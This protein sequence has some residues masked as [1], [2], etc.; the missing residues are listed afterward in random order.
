MSEQQDGVVVLMM[1][2]NSIDGDG[3]VQKAAR[4]MADAGHRVTL[5]GQ[6]VGPGDERPLGAATVRRVPV[7]FAREQAQRRALDR[8]RRIARKLSRA[9]GALRGRA[10]DGG[11]AGAGAR[12]PRALDD[13]VLD[14]ARARFWRALRGDRCW[15]RLEPR[16]L[17]YERAYWPVVDQIRPQ[18]LHAH[19]YRMLGVAVRSARRLRAKGVDVRVVF[20]SHEFLPGV[21][22]PT[23]RWR[24]AYE[25]YEAAHIHEADA[26]VAVSPEMAERI[27]GHHRL[28]VLPSVVMNAP[29]ASGSASGSGD[30]RTTLGLADDVPLLVYIGVSAAKRGLLPTVEA[31][32]DLPGVHLALLTRRNDYVDLLEKTA[33]GL[34][35]ADRLHVLGYVPVEDVVPFVRTASVGVQS[36]VHVENYDVTIATKYFDYAR[37]RLPVVQS[38]V[39]AMAA[40]TRELGNGEV[41]VAEDRDSFVTATRTVL[42]DLPRYR[43]AYDRPG[44][45]EDWTWERQSEVLAEVY[46]R[47]LAT[48]PGTPVQPVRTIGR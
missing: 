22:G 33:A 18:I 17:D 43:A 4:A 47:V 10:A 3:R 8:Y 7:R 46:R 44:L 31:L 29:P 2:D 30:V 26:V 27:A 12:P 14:A 32:A 19:D 13:T 25:A 42:A 37:A 24:I 16:L 23:L 48:T 28:P 38:D 39:R 15:A 5:L 36:M 40:L 41:F 21:G 1:V 6:A 45:L 34:G 11:P 9:T 35:V 20:D